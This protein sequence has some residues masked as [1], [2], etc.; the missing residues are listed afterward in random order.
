MIMS[1][2]SPAFISLKDA[3]SKTGAEAVIEEIRA[4]KRGAIGIRDGGGLPTP[5]PRHHFAVPIGKPAAP[6]EH[7][8]TWIDPDYD[9][10]TGE[11]IPSVMLG[12]TGL[13]RDASSWIHIE[14][15]TI[16]EDGCRRWTEIQVEADLVVVTGDGSPPSL[17][18]GIATAEASGL[19]ETAV[20]NRTLL[21]ETEPPGPK[22]AAA[23]RAM[24]LIRDWGSKGIPRSQSSEEVL[25]LVNAQVAKSGGGLVSLDTVRRVR[26]LRS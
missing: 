23:W 25:R 3:A 10:R 9:D 18:S 6:T 11:V 13:R 12:D 17:Q 7:S 4:G 16:Y 14:E 24:R 8:I 21:A 5:I 15:A 2:P 1:K 22:R 20:G 19:D 26:R